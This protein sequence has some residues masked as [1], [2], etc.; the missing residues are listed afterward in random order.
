MT[1]RELN[2]REELTMEYDRG[3]A[4]GLKAGK[5]EAN[6]AAVTRAVNKLKRDH[7]KERKQMRAYASEAAR[8]LIDDFDIHSDFSGYY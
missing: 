7:A 5:K 3:Y 2:L 1:D 4:E 6:K 8:T